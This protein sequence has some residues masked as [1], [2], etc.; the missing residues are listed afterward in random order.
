MLA[1]ELY[2]PGDPE[3]QVD[4]GLVSNSAARFGS[5]ATSGSAAALSSFLAS[6]LG[7]AR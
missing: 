7:T 6:R 2:R 1:G 5:A 4:A 3:L